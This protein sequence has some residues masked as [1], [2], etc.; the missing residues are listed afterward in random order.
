MMTMDRPG[1]WAGGFQAWDDASSYLATGRGASSGT[2]VPGAVAAR[3]ASSR[4]PGSRSA[5]T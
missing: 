1:V 5:F 2:D 4:A 3:S